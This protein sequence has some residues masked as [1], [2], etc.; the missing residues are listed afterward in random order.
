MKTSSTKIIKR[1]SAHFRGAASGFS[2]IELTM[3]VALIAIL[4][5]IALPQMTGMRRLLRAAG[6][7]RE[8]VA[9]MRYA[10]Q[11][12]MSQRQSFTFQYNNINKQILIIDNNA[13]GP[14][15]LVDPSYPYNPGST[16]ASTVNLA[17]GGLAAAEIAYGIPGGLP[18]GAL[19][20]GV[21]KTPLTNSTL[22]ITFQPDGSV[23]DVNGNPLNRALFIYNNQAPDATAAAISVVGSAGRIKLW[24]YDSG[25]DKYVE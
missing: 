18:P 5:A 19:D 12:A 22:N 2:A 11:L 10:R 13:S 25:V 16:V 1:V 15:V 14:A 23:I 9:Q 3:V 4:T 8:I 21:S 7:T 6:I 24:R 20:D 17:S